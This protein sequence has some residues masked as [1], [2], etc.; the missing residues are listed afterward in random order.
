MRPLS[1][2]FICVGNSCRSPMAEA[3]ARAIGGDRVTACSAG[4]AATGR[5][6]PST[7]EALAA[8]GYPSD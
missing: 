4:L 1:I 3:I 5:V 2:L 6:A 7:L 8:L